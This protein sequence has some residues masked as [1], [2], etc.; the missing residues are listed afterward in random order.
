MEKQEDGIAV[1]RI[2]VVIGLTGL[3]KSAIYARLQ[4]GGK[5]FD[6]SFPKPVSLGARAMGFINSEV[7]EWLKLR[8]DARH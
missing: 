6:P 1:V 3:S 7:Q 4:S 2:K 8:R 5:Y